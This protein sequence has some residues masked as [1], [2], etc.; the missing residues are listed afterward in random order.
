MEFLYTKYR[1]CFCAQ[2]TRFDAPAPGVLS[3]YLEVIILTTEAQ[4]RATATYRKNKTDSISLRINKSEQ[5][6]ARIK[7]AAAL[8]GI[9]ARAYIVRAISEALERDH[10]ADNLKP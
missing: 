7:A 8:H 2:C 5:F 9:T 4:K 1:T 10:V 3:L 6:P